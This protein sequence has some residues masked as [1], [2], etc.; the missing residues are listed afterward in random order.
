[1]TADYVVLALPFSTLRDVELSRS[2][3]PADKRRVI[4]TM[5]MGTNA[6][7]HLEVS[8]KTWPALGYSGAMPDRM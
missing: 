7:I 8:H 6:K 2:G 3:L 1:M 5:G 4:R